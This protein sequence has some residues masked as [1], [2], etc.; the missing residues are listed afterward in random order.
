MTKQ[1]LLRKLETML[2]GAARERL[3]GNIEIQF[4]A[5][6]PQLV[7]KS[8]TEILNHDTEKTFDR[9]YR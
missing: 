4:K 6:Q 1:A 5:G 2:D 3:Y 7:R 8:S 9:N